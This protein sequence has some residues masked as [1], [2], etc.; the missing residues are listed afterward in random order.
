MVRRMHWD[1]DSDAYVLSRLRS[2]LPPL[3]SALKEGKEFVN[4]T[5]FKECS[6]LRCLLPYGVRRVKDVSTEYFLRQGQW[7][8]SHSL[9]EGN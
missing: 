9:S 4:K 5:N 1:A 2:S 7:L 6:T 8:D 3:S